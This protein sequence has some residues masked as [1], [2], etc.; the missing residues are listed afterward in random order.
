MGGRLGLGVP[1][2]AKYACKYQ[3]TVKDMGKQKSKGK[4]NKGN[5]ILKN[6]RGGRGS[7][8]YFKE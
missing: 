5:K 6:N 1:E 2:N 4:Q 8:V 3:S 7:L